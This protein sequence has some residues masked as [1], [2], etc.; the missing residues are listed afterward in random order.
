MGEV[1]LN[2]LLYRWVKID[3]RR[4][5][6]ELKLGAVIFPR[7]ILLRQPGSRW[8]ERLHI[9]ILTVIIKSLLFHIWPSILVIL[10]R[11]NFGSHLGHVTPF[12]QTWNQFIF[13]LIA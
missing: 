13:Q 2:Q 12:L 6:L 7:I 3:P 11:K 1:R 8:K 9:M 5:Q 10:T 4:Q